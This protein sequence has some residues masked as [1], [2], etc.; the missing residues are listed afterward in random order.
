MVLFR[1]NKEIYKEFPEQNKREVS[2]DL[3]SASACVL[4]SEGPKLHR[5]IWRWA[6]KQENYALQR[7]GC[8]PD[9]PMTSVA[10]MKAD[11]Q[12][13]VVLSGIGLGFDQTL[14]RCSHQPSSP[15]QTRRAMGCRPGPWASD[16]RVRS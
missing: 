9:L 15:A 14:S 13:S 4:T 7:S 6:L 11:V 2:L 16:Q 3:N 8:N 1:V 12:R 10:S 5:I